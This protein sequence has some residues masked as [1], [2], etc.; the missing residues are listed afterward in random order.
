MQEISLKTGTSGNAIIATDENFRLWQAATKRGSTL[1]ALNPRERF[2]FHVGFAIT[3]WALVD[4]AVFQVFLKVS[5]INNRAKAAKLFYKS[6]SINDH[7]ALTSSLVKMDHQ[8]RMK[9]W[10]QIE[11]LFGD[12]IGLRNRLA[13]D[14][15]EIIVTAIGSAGHAKQ[16]PPS[17]PPPEWRFNIEPDKLLGKKTAEPVTIDKIIKH[18]NNAVHL[19]TSLAL[20]LHHLE[21]EQKV[22][23]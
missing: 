18:I 5:G 7:F 23:S 20:F 21:R 4:R 16:P 6:T 10:E 15:A 8:K 9:E 17:P 2:F 22:S 11:K 3:R 1:D 19:N 13:H 14:P 12:N